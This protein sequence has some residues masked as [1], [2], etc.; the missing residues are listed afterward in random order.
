[1]KLAICGLGRMGTAFAEAYLKD[2]GFTLTAVWN[3]T[4][5]EIAGA[6]AAASPAAAAASADAVLLMLFDAAASAEVLFGPDGVAAGA[7]PGTLVVNATTVAPEESRRLAAEASAAGLRYVEA[8][9][10]GSIPAVRAGTLH[11]L[12]GGTAEDTAEADALLVPLSPAGSRRR[13]G[14]VGS[15]ASLKLVA[16]LALGAAVAGLHDAV[17]LGAELDVPREEILTVLLR[18]VLGRL[19]EN[20]YERLRADS[21]GDA[22]FTVGALAKDLGLAL[23]S[24]EQPLPAVAAAH[25]L[26]SQAAAATP[27]AD[28]SAL[29]RSVA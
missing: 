25:A 2:D 6:T 27:D 8:P 9:V 12:L 5:R 18:S 14:P 22:D 4:P 24:T 15:A 23:A 19:V 29:G 26:A 11:V 21:Y 10:L 3:R 7:A 1:M 28:I 13:I 20:K 16:N 17:R